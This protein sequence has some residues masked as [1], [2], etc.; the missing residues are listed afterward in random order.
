MEIRSGKEKRYSICFIFL[1][2][3]LIFFI[4]IFITIWW[5]LLDDSQLQWWRWELW[6]NFATV[7][8]VEIIILSVV[9][10]QSSDGSWWNVLLFF[11]LFF[12]CF[13]CLITDRSYD[14][15]WCITLSVFIHVDQKIN[16]FYFHPLNCC[17]PI[18]LIVDSIW[19]NH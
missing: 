16:I 3:L 10:N 8:R 1:F 19:Q 17:I 9:M 15:L 13:V 4:T 5:C 18:H 11:V 14:M 2:F 7:K 6:L 12:F